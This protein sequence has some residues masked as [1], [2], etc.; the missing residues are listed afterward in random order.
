MGRKI[1][2]DSATLMNKGLEL[3]EAHHLFGL[4]EERLGVVVHPQSIVHALVDYVDGSSI[5][6]LANPDMRAPIAFALA[7]PRRMPAPTPPLDLARLGQLTFE[8]PDETRF[9]ALAIARQ[10]L[11]R[12]VAATAVLNAANEVA[13]EAFLAD[14][15]RFPQIAQLVGE[16]LE[17]MEARG[18]LGE[19]MSVDAVLALDR[20]ARQISAERMGRPGFAGG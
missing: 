18:T 17:V 14:R 19:T 1:T 8:A 5:A 7:W 15:L 4:P 16:T 11:R 2:I 20:E 9:P 10:A 6:Q 13:V 12:G 3:I